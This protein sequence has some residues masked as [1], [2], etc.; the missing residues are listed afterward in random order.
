M[1]RPKVLTDRLQLKLLPRTFARLTAL[2]HEDETASG[3]IRDLIE[4]EIARREQQAQHRARAAAEA[5]A[6]GG[7]CERWRV[8]H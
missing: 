7:G 5:D 4:R 1:A 8:G 2:L 6:N 3:V